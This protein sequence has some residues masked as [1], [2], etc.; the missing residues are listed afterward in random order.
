MD[1]RLTA[2]ALG[3]GAVFTSGEAGV[4]GVDETTLRRGRRS[5]E[6]V[7]VRRDAYVL[8]EAWD[9]AGPEER[10]ALRTRAVLRTRRGDV[11]SHRSAPALHGLPLVGVPLDVVDV[12]A[13]VERT[14]TAGG[15]RMHPRATADHVVADGYRCVPLAVALAQVTLRSGVRAAL[16]PVDAALHEGRVSREEVGEV[17]LGL[18]RRPMQQQRAQSVLARCSALS[19]SPGESLTRLFLVDAGF[20]VRAQVP[21]ADEVGLVARVDLLVGERVVVEFDV[22]VKYAGADGRGALV[23]EKRREDRLRAL[24]YVV[25]RVTWA[26]LDHPERVVVRIRRAMAGLSAPGGVVSA[27]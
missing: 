7:R 16:V 25:V 27:S 14:R 13:D 23:A 10:L 11:A 18:A 5:G 19:E 26:D 8:G 22:A 2:F 4:L 15:L 3:R 20:E 1:G 6:L 21:I 12:L 24:G 17:L 9:A